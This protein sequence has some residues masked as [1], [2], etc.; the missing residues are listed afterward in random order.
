[1]TPPR[2][3]WSGD[4][5]RESAEAAEEL[6]RRQAPTEPTL[7]PPPPSPSKPTLRSRAARAVAEVR[8]WA[9]AA[10]AELRARA[11]RA[12][13]QLR[14]RAAS[15]FAQLRS[16]PVRPRARRRRLPRRGTVLTALAML[17]TAGVAYAAVASL[18]SGG[19]GSSRTGITT[20]ARSPARTT[21]PAWLGVETTTF[22]GASGAV[23]VDVVPGSPANAAGLQP[24]DVI[25]QVGSRPIQTPTDLESALTGMRAGQS[26]EIRYE[27]GP[28]AYMTRATLAV[29]PPNAP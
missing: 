19:G 25:T 9:V 5:R 15:A 14:S 18:R 13:A 4:W 22:P 8:L 12:L 28:S 11:A 23:V 24:G 29:R 2:H 3:L 16:R 26:V 27:Q 1:M 21:A 6:A 7:A 17:L 10:V 20:A